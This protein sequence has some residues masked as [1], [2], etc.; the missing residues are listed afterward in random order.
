MRKILL[1]L[2]AACLLASSAN[3]AT[4]IVTTNADDLVANDGTVSLREAISAINAGNDL[5]DPN[6]IAQNP[7]AFGTADRINFNIPSSGVH[8]IVLASALP[9]INKTMTIDGTTQPGWSANTLAVGNNAVLVI[10]LNGAS[11]PG[12]AFIVN[13]ANITFKGLVV[14]RFVTASFNPGNAF[15]LLSAGNTIQGCYLG[16]N[17]AG[18]TASA[19]AGGISVEPT[20][21]PTGSGNNLIGGSTAAARNV[22]VAAGAFAI[23][24]SGGDGNTVQGNYLG[25]NAAGSAILGRSGIQILTKNNLIGGTVALARNVMFSDQGLGLSLRESNATGNVIQG[26]FIGIKATGDGSLGGNTV[27]IDLVRAP[28]N[29]IGGTAAGA[30]NVISGNGSSAL[31]AANTDNLTIQGISS[32]LM[33]RAPRQSPTSPAY[34]LPAASTARLAA[35]PPPRATSSPAI[36][37]TPSA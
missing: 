30:G 16:T 1:P 19:N 12:A 26:N 8:T 18:D 20:G 13:S 37:E 22:I 34:S 28:N 36:M 29:L 33:R 21:Q 25:T 15:R 11:A 5:G 32:A 4:I 17:P 3:A 6:I 2:A 14:N 23:D 35:R 31:N 27:G 7:G 10:E 24:I 9:Q